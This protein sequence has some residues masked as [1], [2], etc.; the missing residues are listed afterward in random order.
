MTMKE[1]LEA[2]R[3]RY[4]LAVSEFVESRT[5]LCA[6]DQLCGAPSFGP[7][8]DMVSLRH[9]VACPDVSGAVTDGV[10]SAIHRHSR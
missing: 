8:P 1:K 4:R 10:A 6:L 3:D 9:P 7:P 2:A 5:E